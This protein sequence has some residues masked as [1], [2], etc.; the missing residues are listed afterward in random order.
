[1]SQIRQIINLAPD[2]YMLNKIIF[3]YDCIKELREYLYAT[4]TFLDCIN[5]SATRKFDK[6]ILL[7][8]VLQNVDL[9]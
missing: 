7:G 2:Y 5:V 6:K 9:S 8:S 1:M 4:N 3:D